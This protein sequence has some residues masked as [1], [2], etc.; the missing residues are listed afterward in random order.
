MNIVI[1]INDLYYDICMNMLYSLKK[2]D[3][4]TAIHIYFLNCGNINLNL[5]NSLKDYC[6]NNLWEFTDIDVS[7]DERLKNMYNTFLKCK[8]KKHSY[9]YNINNYSRVLIPY[10]LSK[11]IDKCL[12]LDADNLILNNL[13]AIYETQ[14]NSNCIG[15]SI[16]GEKFERHRSTEFLFDKYNIPLSTMHFNNIILYNLKEC[17]KIPFSDIEKLLHDSGFYMALQDQDLYNVL[18][19]NKKTPL[20][21]NANLFLY[22]GDYTAAVVGEDKKIYPLGNPKDGKIVSDNLKKYLVLHV[23][24]NI[25]YNN[26]AFSYYNYITNYLPEG[27]LI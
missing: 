21:P 25:K 17:E 5:L 13:K 26:R 10:I 27:Q 11:E 20:A 24:G 12:W 14:L 22:Q 18:Y 8:L 6:K 19:H 1:S 4:D 7:D 9:L 3:S 16:F 23:C 15:V 2:A